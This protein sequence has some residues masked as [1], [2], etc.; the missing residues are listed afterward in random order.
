[1]SIINNL[2]GAIKKSQNVTVLSTLPLDSEKKVVLVKMNKVINVQ[3]VFSSRTEKK[4]KKVTW[5]DQHTEVVGISPKKQVESKLSSTPPPPPMPLSLSLLSPIL[6]LSQDTTLERP[7]GKRTM[8]SQS[9][10]GKIAPGLFEEMAKLQMF[11]DAGKKCNKPEYAAKA[12]TE[13]VIVSLKSKKLAPAPERNKE[14]IVFS[15]KSLEENPMFKQIRDKYIK[16]ELVEAKRAKNSQVKP[17][18]SSKEQ[19][20]INAKI[21]TE[22]Q[23]KKKVE[24]VT[25]DMISELSSKI[26]APSLH[27]TGI[28]LW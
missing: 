24:T 14:S 19:M 7:E 18:F 17:I 21:E 10:K 4:S 20:V 25:K 12:L 3:D 13:D 6:R 23:V 27:K 15:A 11:K 5:S 2:A 9:S 16:A 26:T 8:V 28:K 22:K 1:M